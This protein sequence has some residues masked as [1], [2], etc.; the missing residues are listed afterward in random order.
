MEKPGLNPVQGLA[1]TAVLHGPHER[2][3]R[4]VVQFATKAGCRLCPQK[5]PHRKLNFIYFC[6]SPF[7]LA[8]LHGELEN[9]VWQLLRSR[10]GRGGDCP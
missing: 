8:E 7:P 1:V 5:V 3:P 6:S 9:E 4:K 2:C 10:R